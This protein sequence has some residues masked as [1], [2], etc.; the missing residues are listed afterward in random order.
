MIKSKTAV[1]AGIAVSA[2]ASGAWA[3]TVRFTLGTENNSS[4]FNV[5]AVRHWAE[6]MD[7]RSGGELKMTI[8]DGGALGSGTEVLQQLSGNEIQV[9]TSGPTLIHSMAKPYQ[10]MEAEFVFDDAAHGYRVWTGDLGQELS[11]YMT[12]N[13]DIEITGVGM[14]GARNITAQ[15][16]IQTPDDL[17][18]VKIRVTNPLRTE[19]FKAMGALPGPLPFSELYG[20]LRQGVF[21]A[22]E[23]PISAIHAQ[24][25]YEVQKTLN[26]TQHV[27]SYYVVTS[28]TEFLVGLSDE[29][30]QIF[31]DTAQEAMEWLNARVDAQEQ[32]LLDEMVANGI[33]LVEPD[34]TAFRDVALPVVQAFAA[35]NCREGILDDIAAAR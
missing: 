6:L 31:N 9:S 16:P 10:C 32:S 18:G 34:V 21:D 25:F 15:T 24:K 27:Q 33:E 11:D 14:R 19:V 35:E 22:Q 29:H 3:E 20:G 5:Q 23:N 8:V 28:N 1:M 12:E 30:R 26:M 2:L 4:A 17:K 13:F 7:E